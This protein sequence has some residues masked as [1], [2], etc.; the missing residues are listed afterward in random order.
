MR[1]VKKPVEISIDHDIC[2]QCKMCTKVCYVNVFEWDD[3]NDCAKAS[4]PEDCVMCYHCEVHCPA[5]CINVVQTGGQQ[6]FDAF[7]R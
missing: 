1:P 7:Y 3:K 5:R 6:Y 4:H 2:T